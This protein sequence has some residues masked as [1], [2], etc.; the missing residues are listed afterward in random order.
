MEVI[1]CRHS[2]TAGNQKKQYIGITDQPL[3]PEGE[4]LARRCTPDM[5]VETIYCSPLRRA[6][7]TGR[8]LYPRARVV[9]V[10]A[11]REMDFGLFEQKSYLDL[12]Q[13]PQYQQWLDSGCQDPC[14][15][16]ES[17]AQFARRV[18]QGFEQIVEQAAAQ[19][20]ERV[21][22]VA[23]EETA[24]DGGARVAAALAGAICGEADPARPVGGAALQGIG[25]LATRYSESEVDTL[26]QGG[27]TPV[28]LVGGV[29]SVIRG[30]TTRTKTGEAADATWR[31]LTT[32]LVVDDVIPSIRAALGA[33][34]ARAK[35]TAQTRGAVRSQ[36]ILELEGKVAAEIIS[37]Y[38]EVTAQA[39]ESDPTVCLVTFSF[40]VAQGLNQIWLSAQITV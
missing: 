26:L 5:E 25:S 10:P 28:E 37:G 21:V 35:N 30:V 6:V 2:T 11:L 7:A 20:Q 23:P 40:S 9:L 16:G 31:E 3:C 34:F 36:V 8:I 38:G 24:Q 39:L 18:C 15:G 19:G 29:C 27:V 13:D 33:K 17:I 32:I 22:L 1:L 14:P 4:Q 12:G